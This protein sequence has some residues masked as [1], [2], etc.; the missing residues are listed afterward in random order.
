MK[1]SSRLI[2][3]IFALACFKTSF[4]IESTRLYQVD[5][6]DF[7][8]F[9]EMNISVTLGKLLEM[10]VLKTYY[11]DHKINLRAIPFF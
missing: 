6:Q 8:D 4:L 3:F 2:E 9:G 1:L 10:I 7:S 5:F 11:G